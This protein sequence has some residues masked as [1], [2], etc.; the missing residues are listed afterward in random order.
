MEW[1]VADLHFGDVGLLKYPER[2]HFK[3]I[4]EHDE[5]IIRQLNMFL[6]PG[7]TL[8]VLGDVGFRG[9]GEEGL[10]E[11]ARK[12]R[13][14]EC[15]RKVLIYGNHDKFSVSDARKK[16]GFDE[17][18]KGLYYYE[19]AGAPDLSGKILF[20]H[21]PAREALDNPYVI[22]VHGHVHNYALKLK[23][24]YNV[25]IGQTN[26]VPTN[27][28]KFINLARKVKSRH[29]YFGHEWYYQYYDLPEGG[30][31]K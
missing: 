20:S 23:G 31:K 6:K 30:E 8:Y 21:E 28:K 24:F 4:E 2:C 9:S 25:N 17:V 5:Y 13:R 22:N 16:L 19:N 11:L 26:F 27:M 15:A 1:V 18:H 14:I 7:D 12:I 29:E 10:L 3:S